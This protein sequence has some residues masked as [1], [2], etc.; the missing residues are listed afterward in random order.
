MIDEKEFDKPV[1]L[2]DQ[3]E[4]LYLECQRIGFNDPT[5]APAANLAKRLDALT[6][7][8]FIASFDADEHIL[9]IRQG[10][11]QSGLVFRIDGEIIHIV[12][13]SDNIDARY[14]KNVPESVLEKVLRI[15]EI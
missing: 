10:Y 2:S 9:L 7:W 4:K 13:Q 6:G 1:L 11:L 12:D 14:E 3:V 5:Y 8:H 15:K